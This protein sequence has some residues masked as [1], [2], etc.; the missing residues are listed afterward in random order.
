MQFHVTVVGLGT[1]YPWIQGHYC[2]MMAQRVTQNVLKK[3]IAVGYS[4]K[5]VIGKK[6]IL[7]LKKNKIKK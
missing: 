3:Y 5:T 2:T 1:Y 4:C 6:T 7:L